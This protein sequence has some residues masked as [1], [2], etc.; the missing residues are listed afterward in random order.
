MSGLAEQAPGRIKRREEIDQKVNDG[1]RHV[2]HRVSGE[3]SFRLKKYPKLTS[4]SSSHFLG[5]ERAP[6]SSQFQAKP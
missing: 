5:E 4:Q 3:A 6:F 2:Q 1:L